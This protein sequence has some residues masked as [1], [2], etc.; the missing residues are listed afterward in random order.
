[1][2]TPGLARRL[3]LALFLIAATVGP[4]FAQ[5]DSGQPAPDSDTAQSSD[6]PDSDQAAPAPAAADQPQPAPGPVLLT[7]T[8]QDPS[9]GALPTSVSAP[10]VL[11][12]P[13]ASFS[14]GYLGGA[15]EFKKL[16]P[17]D[18]RVSVPVGSN[19]YSDMAI[20]FD[21]QTLEAGPNTYLWII[22]RL[23][24]INNTD[25]FY[26]VVLW[27]ARNVF[28]IGRVDNQTPSGPLL[29]DGPQ[30]LLSDT[31]ARLTTGAAAT[32]HVQM[33]CAGNTIAFAVNGNAVGS[34]QDTRYANGGVRIGTAATGGAPDTLHLSNLVITQ[35]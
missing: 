22:C 21:L 24:R 34:T 1:M 6:A 4:T 27:P 31:P 16:T 2:I 14:V 35:R 19:A 12:T 5:S 15:Y 30:F 33:T 9:Q 20:D 10:S 13:P 3:T 28:R 32:N 7:D 11:I 23:Q 25:N 26:E 18:A 29:L 17:S 8:F